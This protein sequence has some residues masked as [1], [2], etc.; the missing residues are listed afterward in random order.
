V[1]HGPWLAAYHLGV[2][3]WYAGDR[4]GAVRAWRSSCTA[5]LNPWSLRTLAF[6]STADG[7]H[8]GAA[9]LLLAAAGML[10]DCLPLVVEAA[11]ALSPPAGRTRPSGCWTRHPGHDRCQLLRA[12]ALL[13]LGD[14]AAAQAAFD[15]GFEVADIREARTASLSS[16]TPW[17][18][19]ARCSACTT[20]A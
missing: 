15:A 3:R 7:D 12:T 16:G 14:R 20:S 9:G 18:P 6:A 19:T 11:R 1:T 13:A 17:P 5:R 2:A 4:D 10:P 8:V